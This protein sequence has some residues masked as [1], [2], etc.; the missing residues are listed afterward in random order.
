MKNT[1]YTTFI[2]SLEW[3]LHHIRWKKRCYTLFS[4]TEYICE[5]HSLVLSV[6]ICHFGTK[7][8]HYPFYFFS[9]KIMQK[10]L[11]MTRLCKKTIYFLDGDFVSHL[12]YADYIWH[13]EVD[14][15]DYLQMSIYNSDA[16]RDRVFFYVLN[17]YYY[18]LL[19]FT[20]L[21]LL[22]MENIMTTSTWI[23]VCCLLFICWGGS[24]ER[25]TRGA[26]SRLFLLSC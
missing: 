12:Q 3:V 19:Q 6:T 8:P 15:V 16:K 21:C 20:G 2:F 25:S 9:D 18:F 22:H 14:S 24:W 26:P 5:T 1:I 7:Y 23:Y 13:L 10:R 4:G 17:V 11:F